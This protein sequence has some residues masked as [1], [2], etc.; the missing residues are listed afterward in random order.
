MR[1]GGVWEISVLSTQFCCEPKTSL[2]HKAFVRGKQIPL[3]A[4]NNDEAEVEEEKQPQQ[5][6]CP[7]PHFLV[8]CMLTSFLSLSE[9]RPEGSVC[10]PQLAQPKK[11]RARCVAELTPGQAYPR[12]MTVVVG[13]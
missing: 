6:P 10:P 7:A 5:A 3:A 11:G 13:V 9:T 12:P 4:T 2:K 8:L 1:A